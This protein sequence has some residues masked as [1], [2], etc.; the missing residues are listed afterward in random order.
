MDPEKLQK[1]RHTIDEIDSTI[2]DS[3][4]ARFSLLP[5][6]V[7]QKHL[8]NL[9]LADEKHDGEVI[10]KIRQKSSDAGINPNVG[11]KIFRIILAESQRIQEGLE[12]K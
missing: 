2:I 7:S 1:L 4:S 3:L 5:S 6:I 12:K 8:L 11:E 9:P 10:Q